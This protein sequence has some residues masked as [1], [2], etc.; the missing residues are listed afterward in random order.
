[1]KRVGLAACAA[2]VLAAGALAQEGN[3]GSMGPSPSST[4]PEPQITP[5]TRTTGKTKPP[6]KPSKEEMMKD[7]SDIASSIQLPCVVSD[8]NLLGQGKAN[9]GGQ[10]L[11]T[12][13]VEVACQS[14]MGYLLTASEGQKAS[15]FSCFAADHAHA[16]D[17]QGVV[18]TLPANADV[19][20]AAGK[21]LSGLGTACQVTNV[22]WIGVNGGSEFTEIACSGGNG[23]VLKGPM[24][25]ASSTPISA[26]SCV[27]SSKQGI[28]CKMSSN[29]AQPITL[30][31]FKQALAQHNVSCNAANVR[32]I[33]KETVLKRHVVEFQCLQEHPDGLVA[34]IPLSDSQAPFETMNCAQA[35]SKYKIICTYVKQ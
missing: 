2:F 15:G 6:P 11:D 20:A 30:D 5:Q 17:P 10:M 22:N 26:A 14:G 34:L 24:P 12:K 7:A 28:S 19:K 29:G 1:M 3:Y 13:N 4:Q 25:G 16:R 27:D 35:A 32:S 21:V 18:C 23:F 31:T 33:G 9:V 8:A